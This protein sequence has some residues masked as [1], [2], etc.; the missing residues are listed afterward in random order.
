MAIP[1]VL[2][3][4]VE[5]NNAEDAAGMLATFAENGSVNDWGNEYNGQKAVAGWIQS[6]NISK[7]SRFKVVGSEQVS[8]TE[9]ILNITVTGEGFNG[10]GPL[11]FTLKDDKIVSLVI[12]PN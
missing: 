9:W 8:A 6:D 2:T 5:T 3:T 4:F 7:H 12:E 1:E 10:T 11:R